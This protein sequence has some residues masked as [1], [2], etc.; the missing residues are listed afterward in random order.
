MS[1]I[2]VNDVNLPQTQASYLA[3]RIAFQETLER[4]VLARQFPDCPQDGFG[5]LTE[6]PFL[7]NVSP[8]VQL[9][10]LART[11][12]NHISDEAIE[13]SLLDEAVI[14]AACERAPWWMENEATAVIKRYLQH[15]PQCSELKPGREWAKVFRNLHREVSSDADFLLVS[16]FED[17]S[18]EDSREM[19]EEWGV[20]C[21]RLEPLFDV[22]AQWHASPEMRSA[23]DGL[24]MHREIE[25]ISDL[26]R[27]SVPA[28]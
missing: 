25:A 24:L 10:L 12:K 26:F 5:Y 6:V 20:D 2:F 27:L 9:D 8:E 7:T 14:Y 19:K 17:M 21:E 1:M 15:G 22:L 28:E 4:I 18:P 23:L 3:F 11:W 13:G 16:Q